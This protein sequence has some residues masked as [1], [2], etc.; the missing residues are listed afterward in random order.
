[1]KR[2]IAVQSETVQER[3]K[4]NAS[5]ELS[6]VPKAAATLGTGKDD[7]SAGFLLCKHKDERGSTDMNKN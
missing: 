4:N 6:Q 7:D 1:M 3:T 2:G 5:N